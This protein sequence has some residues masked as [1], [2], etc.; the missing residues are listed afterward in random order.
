MR[1]LVVLFALSLTIFATNSHARPDYAVKYKINRCT[2][3]HLSPAGGG[4]RNSAGK[5]FGYRGQ[6]KQKSKS[7][8]FDNLYADLKSIYYAPENTTSSKGGYGTM[9]AIVGGH[10]DVT[11]FSEKKNIKLVLQQNVGGFGGSTVMD[12]FVRFQNYQDIEYNLL[13][14]QYVLVGRFHSPFG[15]LT[16]EHRSYVKIQTNNH[17][18]NLDSGALISSD[19]N[20]NIHYDLAL[21][22][23]NTKSGGTGFSESGAT[24][25][26]HV[27]NLR[28]LPSKLPFMLGA[29]SSTHKTIAGKA[30]LSANAL[31]ILVDLPS[32]SYSLPNMTVSF[33]YVTASNY[34]PSL[35]SSGLISDNSYATSVATADSKGYTSMLNWDISDKWSLQF[36]HDFL[37][38]NKEFL[39]DGYTRN[40]IGFKYL[41]AP[42]AF[43]MIRHE[44]AKAGQPNEKSGSASVGNSG[45]SWALLQVTI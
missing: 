13:K 45:A 30:D 27:F 10:F 36:K 44:E 25:W 8:N 15:L 19:I 5:Y 4:I 11:Q 42:N 32:I 18:R 40:G 38:L 34:N 16:D 12:T 41:F 3:C 9:A 39:S 22:N 1:T 21:V 20:E 24:L 26:G 2:Q 6:F 29:S 23:G 33:E 35:A 43:V 31:Y 17:W 37:A 7:V 28:W 14:P